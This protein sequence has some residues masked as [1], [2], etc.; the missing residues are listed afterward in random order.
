MKKRETFK[1]IKFDGRDWRIDKFDAMTGSYI[2]Y[3]LIGEN[4]PMGIKIDGI[5]KAP[6]GS[7]IMSKADFIELQTDC[8]KVC[9]EILDA[10]PSPVMNDNGS[11]G[12]EG[13]ENNAKL[14]L[15]LTVN[16]LVWNIADFFDESL[17]QTLATG[18]LG[19][20]LPDVKI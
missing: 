5:P 17:L 6:A 13:V 11:W 16:A 1:K 14:A 9:Y 7:K 8:L 15:A 18:V 10:G 12:V 20:V 4:L 3:K 2:A 19:S